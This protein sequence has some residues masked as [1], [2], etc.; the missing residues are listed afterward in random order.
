VQHVDHMLGYLLKS[1]GV[2]HEKRLDV[3]MTVDVLVA[4]Y[5]QLYAGLF[6][7]PPIP[8]LSRQLKRLR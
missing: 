7:S 2:Y 4:A 3:S 5:E 1:D 6:L 8:I